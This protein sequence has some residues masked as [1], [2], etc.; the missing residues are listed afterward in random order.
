MKTPILPLTVAVLLITPLA[1]G[2]AHAQG[3]ETATIELAADVLQELAAIPGKSIPPSLMAD[4][5]GVVIVPDVIKAGFVIGAR[6]GH[7]VLMVRQPPGTWS[8]PVFVTLTGASIGW[9]V[10]VQATDVVLVFKTRNGLE[11]ILRGQGKLTLG[12]DIAVAAGPVGRQAEADTDAQ[13]KAEIY[14]YSRSRGLFAGLAVEGAA[15]LVS[16]AADNHFYGK[17]GITPQQIVA[18]PPLAV[19]ALIRAQNELTRM[20][21]PVPVSVPVI[22][23]PPVPPTAPQPQWEPAPLAP[24]PRPLPPG[25]P[26]KPQ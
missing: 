15:L 25:T 18:M 26:L 17:P 23:G 22:P 7:G 3:R 4:A 9:Q 16:A 12:A 5:Q 6:H 20:S 11:R 1:T 13:L 2:R 24:A 8:N 19:P 14:S 21:G 10:G